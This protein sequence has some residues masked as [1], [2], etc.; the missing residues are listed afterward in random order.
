M[1]PLPVPPPEYG[2]P[3]WSA[4]PNDDPAKTHAVLLAAECWRR[5]WQPDA[6][7]W[8]ADATEREIRRRLRAMSADLSTG[9]D[10]RQ[11]AT[12]PSYAELE[13]RRATPPPTLTAECAEPGCDQIHQLP[14]HLI[15]RRRPWAPRCWPEHHTTEEAA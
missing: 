4:L 1:T 11:I 5:Y 6:Q 7:A 3:A 9:L 15:P 8:R 14:A 10:W 2:S 12:A 13:R